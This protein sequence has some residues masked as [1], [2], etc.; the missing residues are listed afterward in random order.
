[1]GWGG[2][3]G[4]QR[5]RL[6]IIALLNLILKKREDLDAE[7]VLCS[8]DVTGCLTDGTASE[9]GSAAD[10]ALT[11][12]ALALNHAGQPGCNQQAES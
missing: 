7:G 9:C 8:A 3:I 5:S 4:F 12:R 11:K 6:K 1:M 10:A 2:G